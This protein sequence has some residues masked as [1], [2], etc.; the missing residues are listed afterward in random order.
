MRI[1]LP[2]TSY[3]PTLPLIFHSAVAQSKLK[4]DFATVGHGAYAAYDHRRA[5]PPN[6]FPHP[7]ENPQWLVA[8]IHSGFRV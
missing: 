2:H 4:D 1:T 8:F 7:D 6:D 3:I 5:P